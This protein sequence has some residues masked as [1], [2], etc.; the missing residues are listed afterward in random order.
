MLA[1]V[2]VTC[3]S[4]W[5]CGERGLGSF[6]EDRAVPVIDTINVGDDRAR[7]Q[8]NRC[9]VK[10]L[11][12]SNLPPESPGTITILPGI[13]DLPRGGWAG[14][15]GVVFLPDVRWARSDRVIAHELGHALGFNH[16][17]RASVMGGRS[18][19]RPLDCEGL[20]ATYGG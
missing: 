19:V 4:Y 13:D 20:R 10:R 8:W 6:Y 11:V 5:P 7:W 15:H 17:R 3:L 1:L 2:L 14:D 16:T 12:E 18:T 9:G